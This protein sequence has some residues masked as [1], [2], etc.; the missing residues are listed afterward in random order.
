VEVFMR[1]RLA[2]L[3]ALLSLSSLPITAAYISI[4]DLTEDVP[5]V[6]T[7]IPGPTIN[8]A[9]EEVSINLAVPVGLNPM[10][11]GVRSV[12]LVNQTGDPEGA[13]AP[14]D[15]ITLT[16][17][18]VEIVDLI[19]VQILQILFQSDGAPGFD[20][21]TAAL[22]LLGVPTIVETGALQDV[23]ALLDTAPVLTVLVASDVPGSSSA[24]P[25]PGTFLP[26]ALG[27]IAI[28]GLQRLLRSSRRA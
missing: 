4:S 9:S 20:V 19:P 7:D 11:P 24:V 1:I 3:L 17:G 22:L 28:G 6:L 15:F 8:F 10:T 21:N 27:C 14:S 2:L 5:T 13:G 16:V 25:E 18:D 12:L 26:A 23:S